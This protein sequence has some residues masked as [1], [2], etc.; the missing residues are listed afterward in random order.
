MIKTSRH[1]VEH[2]YYS[3]TSTIWQKPDK[4]F[5]PTTSFPACNPV[6]TSN[7]FERLSECPTDDVDVTSA[8]AFDVQMENARLQRQ[9]QFLRDQVANSV[10]AQQQ[11][12]PISTNKSYSE[13]RNNSS[14]QTVAIIG[15]SITKQLDEKKLS[16]REKNVTVRAFSGATTDDIKTIVSLLPKADLIFA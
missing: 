3:N 2:S 16:N 6:T 4:T 8:P 15:D 7:Q 1:L 11:R 10:S 5:E 13:T 9:V 14:K 12:K